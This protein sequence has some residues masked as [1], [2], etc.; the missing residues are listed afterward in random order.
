LASYEIGQAIGRSR[1]R[2]DAYKADLRAT[3]QMDLY[4][5]ILRVNRLHMPQERMASRLG[6]LQQTISLHLQEMPALAFLV[7]TDLSKRFTVSQVAE[8][9]ACPVGPED[10]TWGGQG[11]CVVH[12]VGG[13][14]RS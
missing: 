2:V 6:V 7:N 14:K 5:K 12:C 8:K 13:Q 11:L 4:L 10:R 9:N 3:F 1:Q